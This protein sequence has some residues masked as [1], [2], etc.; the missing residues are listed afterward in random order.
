MATLDLASIITRVCT[1][2]KEKFALKSEVDKK[3]DALVSGVNIKTLNSY[4]LLGSGN[5]SITSRNDTAWLIRQN[6]YC[7]KSSDACRGIYRLYFTSADSTMLVPINTS[8]SSDSTTAKTLNTRPINPFGAI[9]YYSSSI[10]AAGY[11]LTPSLLWIQ[12]ALTIGYSYVVNLTSSGP[13]YL[14][15]S[16]NSDGS[17]VMLEVVTALPTSDDGYIYIYLGNASSSTSMVLAL[18]HPVY[19][20]DGTGIRL[21][22]GVTSASGVSF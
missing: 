12:C 7:Y 15:C 6:D 13:V 16:P 17:A 21:W 8:T 5:V 22:T 3:Q 1:D 18:N 19:Y 10:S 11:S 9:Y 2:L 20:H 14:K 4:S